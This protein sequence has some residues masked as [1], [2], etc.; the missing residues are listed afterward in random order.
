[1]RASTIPK[2]KL[3]EVA[4]PLEAIN[5]A[6]ANEKSIRQRHIGDSLEMRVQGLAHGVHH[7]RTHFGGEVV[8]VVVPLTAG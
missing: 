8:I 5:K 6:C 2:K 3:I 7:Q 1:M 4:L